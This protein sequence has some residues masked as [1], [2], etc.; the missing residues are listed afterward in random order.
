M[1]SSSPEPLV[2]GQPHP[3]WGS[4][5]HGLTYVFPPE[6]VHATWQ[7]WFHRLGYLGIVLLYVFAHCLWIA[8]LVGL[9]GLL[10]GFL[11]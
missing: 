3:G 11:L 2:V 7:D 4:S 10:L 5:P 9:I 1:S 6:S 8:L